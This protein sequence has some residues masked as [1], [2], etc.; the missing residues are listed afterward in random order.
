M[1][2][3]ILCLLTAQDRPDIVVA[4]F[5]GPHYAG[6]IRTGTA[7][8]TG[9]AHGTLPNQMHVS[10]YLGKGLVNSFNGGDASTG[11]LTSPPF[12]IERKHMNF[13]I[14]GGKYPGQTCINLCF[15]GRVI[16]TATGPNNKPGGSEELEWHSWNVSELAGVTVTL[17]I[18]DQ[19]TGSW[20]HICVDHIVQSDTAKAVTQSNVKRSIQV[21][22]KYLLLPVKNK[23]RM[24]NLSVMHQGVTVRQMEIELADGD[25][26]WWA[27]LDVSSWKGQQLTLMADKLPADSQALKTIYCGNV[28]PCKEPM[29]HEKHRPQLHFSSRRGWLNDPNGLVFHQGEYH[30]FYQHN[31]YGWDWGNMHWGHAVSK[32][33]LHWEELPVAIYPRKFGDWVFS[34]SCVVDYKNTSGWGTDT[35]PP[36]VAAFT[37]TG[38]GECI[39]YSN[40]RGRTWK[41]YDKNPVIKHNGR[42]PRI[43]WHV[44]SR[45]WVMAVYD[46]EN[47]KRNISIYTSP[48]LK[49][50]TYQSN[51]LDFFE[52]PD[53]YQ[54]N[55]PGK[56]AWTHDWC[57]SAASQDY[58]FS[59][60]DGKVFSPTSKIIKGHYGK[61]YYAAQTYAPQ[62]MEKP[63]DS[64]RI[65]VFWFQ[66]PTPGM[67]FNQCMSTP[68]EVT[69]MQT[70][71]GYRL[72]Y[73]P[74]R[75]IETLRIRS[76]DLLRGPTEAE[77]ADI[78]I[79]FKPEPGTTMEL[80]IRGVKIEYEVDKKELR[81]EGMKAK[82][83]KDRPQFRVIL[84][85]TS[86]EIIA[87]DT[88]LMPVPYLFADKPKTI[89]LKAPGTNH[90][91]TVHELRSVWK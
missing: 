51:V 85:R 23:A 59:K 82:M 33:L 20:G 22:Q 26:D 55:A 42:D 81:C 36:M 62:M 25:P 11:T 90:F 78:Q 46:E 38:R 69:N 15:N 58:Q 10:G 76:H 16:R 53:L 52:C 31:P 77:L 48:N 84:D 64:R 86:L 67:P 87:D 28:I 74:I 63:Y 39:V 3:I 34:G 40:D 13:L 65:I 88:I 5:E 44:D 1:L 54:T 60:F 35:E 4:D 7:F 21:T 29:Y 27:F 50:W 17:Q 8:G 56:V 41:E 37:S 71:E 68:L 72:V 14:G 66:S 18:V 89:S 30:L 70:P 83:W 12:T 80:Q 32:D 6:W 73:R 19:H 91:A 24:R 9:P 43:F 2:P 75:E 47:K 45:Q 57:L 79:D 49:E 61:G